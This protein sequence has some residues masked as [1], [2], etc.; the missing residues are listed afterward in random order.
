VTTKK[1]KDIQMFFGIGS[2]DLDT[3]MR[4]AKR[5]LDKNH[6]VRVTLKIKGR[7]VEKTELVDKF[8]QTVKS[9]FEDY[10]L[11]NT[12]EKPRD[13]VLLYRKE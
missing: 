12:T 13:T 1:T 8:L 2:N 10:K 11:I 4:N 6:D 5:L 9:N 3:K 7:Y